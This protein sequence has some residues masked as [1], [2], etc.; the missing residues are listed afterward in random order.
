MR[1]GTATTAGNPRREAVCQLADGRI[2]RLAEAARLLRSAGIAIDEAAAE[3]LSS[4]VESGRWLDE[5]GRALARRIISAPPQNT[6]AAVVAADA[7]RIGP[8]V[9]APAKFIATGRNYM[10]H[11]REGQEIWAKRGKTVVQSSFPTAFV[12]FASCIIADGERILIPPGVEKVDYEI[13]LAVVIGRP[14]FNI[15]EAEA[16]DHVAG[17][18]ICNDLGARAIQHAEME[19]QIGI[20]MAKNQPTFAPLGPWL[21]TTDEIPD[22]QALAL[23]LTVNGEERQRATTADM[24]FPVRKLVSYWSR[25]GLEPGD[26]I[27]TGTPAGV[28]V[29]RPD[30][31]P[32]YLKA[33]DV[34]AAEIERIGTLINPVAD[35]PQ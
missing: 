4:E 21:V 11:L 16:L 17:Y 28:A 34:V 18:T 2:L 3:R 1:L 35:A 29:A 13:E 27:I 15:G 22:P 8:P 20:V 6:A 24:I 7:V 33:G 32:F 30:P 12:K 9:P 19:H 14:T 23:S 5:S 26:V 25:I 10:D 31:A